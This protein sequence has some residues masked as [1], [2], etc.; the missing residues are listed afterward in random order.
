MGTLIVPRWPSAPYWLFIFDK[1]LVYRNYV[2]EVI[3]FKNTHGIYKKGTKP[4]FMIKNFANVIR[5]GVFGTGNPLDING[6]TFFGTSR[7]YGPS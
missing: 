5:L 6:N 4:I 2:T 1:H 7:E 3:E